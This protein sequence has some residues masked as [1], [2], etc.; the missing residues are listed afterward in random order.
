MPVPLINQPV[1]MPVLLNN[2]GFLSVVDPSSVTNTALLQPRNINVS[3]NANGT[4]IYQPDPGYAGKDTFQY[5][6]CSTPTP[7]VCDVATVYVDIAVC[8]APFNQNV[9]AGTV[10]TD[11]NNDG[12]NNDRVPGSGYRGLFVC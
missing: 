12:N 11:K 3:I 6:V 8:P 7:I 5:N 9:I 1:T 4:V 2:F 10:F